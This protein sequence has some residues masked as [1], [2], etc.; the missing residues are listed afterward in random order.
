MSILP[1]SSVEITSLP[2]VFLDIKYI[3]F[4]QQISGTF[5]LFVWTVFAYIM[6]M[7][8]REMENTKIHCIE[9]DKKLTEQTKILTELVSI[10]K[11]IYQ[12]NECLEKRI[13]ESEAELRNTNKVIEN[14][15]SENKTTL[16]KLKEIVNTNHDITQKYVTTECKM[17]VLESRMVLLEGSLAHTNEKLKWG[18]LD[19]NLKIQNMFQNNLRNT[20]QISIWVD[21]MKKQETKYIEM[22]DRVNKYTIV[23]YNQSTYIPIMLP[24][25]CIFENKLHMLHNNRGTTIIITQLHYLAIKKIYFEN[26][27]CDYVNCKYDFND[28][29]HVIMYKCDNN[30]S[31]IE[32]KEIK[33]AIEYFNKHNIQVILNE[34]LQQ[35]IQL[36]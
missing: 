25:N 33:R 15:R 3:A 11:D 2:S 27:L 12:K 29:S 28:T 1:I 31:E 9:L 21:R 34:K 8:I 24:T 16:Y 26:I 17:D 18:I 6:Y 7:K 4:T 14:I 30:Y 35:K 32:I 22:N 36:L 20:E 13:L 5:I 10:N 23:G 19:N